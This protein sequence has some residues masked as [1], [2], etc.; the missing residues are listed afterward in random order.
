LLKNWDH[1]AEFASAAKAG[2]DF[3]AYTARL[4][5]APFQNKI[6]RENLQ[7]TVKVLQDCSAEVA[8]K[9]SGLVV[10]AGEN[11]RQLLISHVPRDGLADHLPEVRGQGQVAAF[12][13]L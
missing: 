3:V 11:I 4:E 10:E 2:I 5:A 6:K 7:Q 8:E 9:F 1:Q 12:I 13:K